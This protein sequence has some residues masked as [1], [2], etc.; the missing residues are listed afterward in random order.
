MPSVLCLPSE[1]G[2][3]SISLIKSSL[4]T[5]LQPSVPQVPNYRLSMTIPDW[6]QAIQNYMKTLQYPSNQALG[7]PGQGTGMVSSSLV[8]GLSP[9]GQHMLSKIGEAGHEGMSQREC[10][11]STIIEGVIA[12]VRPFPL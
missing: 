12:V 1:I 3:Q 9:V 5:S 11:E 7:R 8:A 2:P 4:C 6:L 10:L